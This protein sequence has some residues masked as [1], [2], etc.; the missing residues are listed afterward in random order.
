M[1]K[2]AWNTADAKRFD[3]LILRLSDFEQRTFRFN[4]SGIRD[5]TKPVCCRLAATQN[6]N[7]GRDI[8]EAHST[9]FVAIGLF[10]VSARLQKVYERR[11]VA[12]VHDAV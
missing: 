7:K 4:F 8:R 5:E 2:Q 6:C 3:K 12:E 10:E 1:M 11:D 9:V